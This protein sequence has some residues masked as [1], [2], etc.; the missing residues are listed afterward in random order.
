MRI[1]ITG[2]NGMLGSDLVKV[3]S[4]SYE[5]FGVGLHENKQL[6]I[7]Y[8]QID[9]TVR[10]SV[11][12]TVAQIQPAIIIHSAAYTDVDGC[13]LN[14]NQAYLMNTKATQYVA[15]ASDQTGAT[16]FFISSDY[17]FDGK[18]T[19]PYLEVDQGNPIS[20][21]GRSKFEAE[22]WLKANSRSVTII[23]SSWL[24]GNNGRNFFKAILA[25]ISKKEPLQVVNDQYGA[26]TYTKDLAEGIASLIKKGKRVKGF[27]I[28]HLANS[29]KTT[30]YEVAKKVIEKVGEPIMITPISSEQLNR[31]AKRPKNSI[32]DMTKI[33]STYQL[34]LRSWEDAFNDYWET[35]LKKEW[36]QP[37]KRN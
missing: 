20:V 25:R 32:F 37:S 29:G 28:Y 36:F 21:Y 2:S 27:D 4:P 26:P 15:E 31:P 30:W 24:Y 16:L 10:A 22:E 14:P 11:L 5:V 9:L 18:K 35:E 34:S 7:P 17:I 12:K 13:E 3:L 8:E 33:K 19:S 23:R 6:E 1:L